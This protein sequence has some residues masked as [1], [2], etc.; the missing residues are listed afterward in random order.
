MLNNIF[1]IA[2]SD[3]SGTTIFPGYMQFVKNQELIG[4]YQPVPQW[5][6]SPVSYF[7]TA[8]D[9]LPLAGTESGKMKEVMLGTDYV[10]QAS[11]PGEVEFKFAP[12]TGCAIR[13]FSD[14]NYDHRFIIGGTHW[15]MGMSGEEAPEVFPYQFVIDYSHLTGKYGF[16]AGIY[17][18]TNL[19]LLPLSSLGPWGLPDFYINGQKVFLENPQELS[20]DYSQVSNWENEKNYIVVLPLWDYHTGDFVLAVWPWGKARTERNF[21]LLKHIWSASFP[22]RVE[23]NAKFITDDGLSCISLNRVEMEASNF[24]IPVDYREFTEYMNYPTQPP[25]L[26]ASELYFAGPSL[27]YQLRQFGAEVVLS[28][29]NITIAN[30]LRI[31][32]FPE[33]REMVRNFT[34]GWTNH[35]KDW[36]LSVSTQEASR[37]TIGLNPEIFREWDSHFVSSETVQ[38]LLSP[39]K[40]IELWGGVNGHLSTRLFA[41]MIDRISATP[42]RIS[43]ECSDFATDIAKRNLWFAPL[44]DLTGLPGYDALRFLFLGLGYPERLFA[45]QPLANVL[46]LPPEKEEDK[47]LYIPG[48]SNAWQIMTEIA[49]LMGVALYFDQNG[50]LRSRPLNPPLPAPNEV[51]PIIQI[52]G[53]D[54]KLSSLEIGSR[55]IND[56]VL[57]Y[58]EYDTPDSATLENV[59]SIKDGLPPR[60]SVYR[61]RPVVITYTY[62]DIKT[63]YTQLEEIMSTWDRAPVKLTIQTLVLPIDFELGKVYWVIGPNLVRKN[64]IIR[65][66]EGLYRVAKFEV[67]SEPSRPVNYSIELDALE[68]FEGRYYR[69][70]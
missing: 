12:W 57:I 17:V 13:L 31:A 32:W 67:S 65:L 44:I 6:D 47:W 11:G 26:L 55:E 48:K 52:D 35:I 63:L 45:I 50:Y 39:N 3:W 2:I 20:L 30:D 46:L 1:D 68:W 66:Y 19:K 42:E 16:Y 33:V 22:E 34:Y 5:L 18:G 41:G 21:L 23:L 38:D 37:L 36:N 60:F 14:I 53:A 58:V 28:F 56:T 7:L 27:P 64:N 49:N 40:Y 9:F 15:V 43:I 24:T 51:V 29:N 70:F 61:N 10:Y 69:G 62:N 4:Q 54:T 59:I 25:Q 8:L